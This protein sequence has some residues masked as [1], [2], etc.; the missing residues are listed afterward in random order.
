MENRFADISKL[1]ID[2]INKNNKTVVND[3]YFTSPFKIMKPFY[4]NNLMKLLQMSASPGLM[5]GDIQKISIKIGE[6]CK[7]EIYSQS[8]E[9]IHKML[10][11]YAERNT[12][13]TLDKNS[14]FCYNPLPVIPYADSAFKNCI[15]INLADNSSAFVYTDI[16]S[17]G[18]ITRGECFQYKYYHSI[19][20]LYEDNNLEYRDNTRFEPEH[21]D[22]SDIG[23]YENYTH[24]LSMV[25]CNIDAYDNVSQIIEDYENPCGIT[26]N[27]KGYV[28]IKALGRR[29]EDLQKLSEKIKDKCYNIY[30]NS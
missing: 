2:I 3:I 4:E 21:M 19:L 10:K 22:L 16:L 25:I 30:I 6:G 15:N 24:L 11:G 27:N 8:F 29:S 1:D 7:A 17:G 14:F 9:K 28:V 18:R 12:E 20:N 13:I 23:L 26:C 5:E